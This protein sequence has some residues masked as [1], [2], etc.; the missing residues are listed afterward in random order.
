MRVDKSRAACV[1]FVYHEKCAVFQ[2]N[3]QRKFHW[4]PALPPVAVMAHSR[5][6]Y[7]RCGSPN[8]K[9]P[10]GVFEY[11]GLV[12]LSSN[13]QTLKNT[14]V[15]IE[16]SEM[17]MG[18]SRACLVRVSPPPG[19]LVFHCDLVTVMAHQLLRKLRSYPRISRL[20]KHTNNK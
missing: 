3:S 15:Q 5:G 19:A 7:D 16:E 17:E 4:R 1:R 8:G 9:Y 11:Q 14:K 20:I 6:S 13:T 18:K 10:R 12:Y 2:K